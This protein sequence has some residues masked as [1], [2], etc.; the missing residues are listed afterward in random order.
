MNRTPTKP[1]SSATFEFSPTGYF[2]AIY[3]N[4]PTDKDQATLERALDRLIQPAHG[5]W[6]KRLLWR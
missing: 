1:K 5:S 4:I 3:L 6:I 2:R